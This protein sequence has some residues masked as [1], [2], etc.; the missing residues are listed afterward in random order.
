[1]P[2]GFQLKYMNT[3]NAT[4]SGA[5]PQPATLL[6]PPKM[7]MREIKQIMMIWPANMLA[8]KTYDQGKWLG[9][10]AQE[11]QPVPGSA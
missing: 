2:P 11:F 1:M 3:V 10:Y 4:E 8:K 5:K 7:K 6:N 9:K